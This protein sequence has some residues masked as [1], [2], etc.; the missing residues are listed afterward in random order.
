MYPMLFSKTG[1]KQN[2]FFKMLMII[3][4]FVLLVHFMSS[5]QLPFILDLIYISNLTFYDICHETGCLPSS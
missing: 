2:R 3:F 1:I 5:C 4:F